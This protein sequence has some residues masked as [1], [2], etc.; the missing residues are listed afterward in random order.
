MTK[1]EQ[2][3]LLAPLDPEQRDALYWSG[4]HTRVMALV[5]AELARRRVVE[6]P[7]GVI[8]IVQG[9]GR[10][11]VPLAAA[12]ALVGALLL[13]GR[14]SPEPALASVEELLLGGLEEEGI[15]PGLLSDELPDAASLL[16]AV[17]R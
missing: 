7:L 3:R 12:A 11:L 6:A 4:F 5:E 1:R 8:Q 10:I 17:E 14:H 16:A 15:A 13:D 9:W 2:D